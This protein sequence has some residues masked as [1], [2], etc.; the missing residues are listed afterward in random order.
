MGIIISEKIVR[1]I[2]SEENLVVFKIMRQKYSSYQG[3][4]SPEVDNMIERD[5]YVDRSN[6]KKVNGYNR[7]SYSSRKDLFITYH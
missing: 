4:I 2:M 3:E 1:R 5:F 6:E 7:V